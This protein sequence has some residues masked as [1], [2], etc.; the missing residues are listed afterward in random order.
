[1]YSCPVDGAF[2]VRD[3][4]DRLRINS[5]EILFSLEKIAVKSPVLSFL[6]K[7]TPQ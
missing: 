2:C 7:G 1:M 6:R 5:T 4:F 3:P